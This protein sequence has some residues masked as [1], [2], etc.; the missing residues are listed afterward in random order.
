MDAEMLKVI[1][2]G[3]EAR[4]TKL[5]EEVSR[6]RESWFQK[7]MA[8]VCFKR[9]GH[10]FEKMKSAVGYEADYERCKFCGIAKE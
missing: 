3:Y 5:E 7:R 2:D 8:A 4:I 6:H 1:C 9:G 10:E